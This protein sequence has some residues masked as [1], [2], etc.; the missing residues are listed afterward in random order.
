[1]ITTTKQDI[2]YDLSVAGCELSLPLIEDSERSVLLE[3]A[4]WEGLEQSDP[5]LCKAIRSAHVALIRA[6]GFIRSQDRAIKSYRRML[7]RWFP[8]LKEVHG[9]G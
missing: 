7:K 5:D 8:V 2:T 3:L 9:V 6:E 1:M 4:Q